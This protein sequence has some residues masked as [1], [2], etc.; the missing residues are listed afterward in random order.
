[1]LSRITRYASMYFASKIWYH[2]RKLCP[3]DPG[4]ASLQL[5]KN[6]LIYTPIYVFLFCEVVGRFGSSNATDGCVATCAI[7]FSMTIF[8]LHQRLL[9]GTIQTFWPVAILS[10]CI[11]IATSRFVKWSIALEIEQDILPA[12]T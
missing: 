1:M 2:R 8:T 10:Q 12:A 6:I 4:E 11:L 5:I 7:Y 9:W 3:I